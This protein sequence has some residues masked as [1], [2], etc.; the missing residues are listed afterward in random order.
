MIKKEG[1]LRIKGHIKTSNSTK[2]LITVAT[3]VYNGQDYFYP[4]LCIS[5]FG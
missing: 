3:V 2:P 5:P 4:R 1:G